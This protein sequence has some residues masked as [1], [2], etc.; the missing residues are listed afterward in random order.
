MSEVWPEIRVAARFE[1]INWSTHGLTRAPGSPEAQRLLSANW[2][3]IR[4]EER[5]EDIDWDDYA[6]N[7]Y[8]RSQSSRSGERYGR[9]GGPFTSYEA[10]AL[11]SSVGSPDGSKV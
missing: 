11:A 2:D 7:R 9:L 5:F 8:S 3:E 4:R 10:D 1:D 6:N